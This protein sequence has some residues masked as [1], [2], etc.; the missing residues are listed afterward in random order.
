V[1]TRHLLGRA[2]DEYIRAKYAAAHAHMPTLTAGDAFDEALI[3]FARMGPVCARLADSYAAVMEPAAALR[4][5]LV[6]LLAIL[7]TRPPFHKAIDAPPGTGLRMWASLLA[8]G[9]GAAVSLVAGA[10][11]F[12]PV[13]LIL[14][15]TRKTAG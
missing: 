12:M 13:R 1:F 4:K 5:K 3:A 11:V 7:E 14:A 2:P 15:L 8:K 6:L 9:L 10:F